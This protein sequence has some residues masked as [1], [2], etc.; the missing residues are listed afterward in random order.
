MNTEES[1]KPKVDKIEAIRESEE[2]QAM[3]EGWTYVASA[4]KKLTK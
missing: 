4:G 1:E 2:F 3:D